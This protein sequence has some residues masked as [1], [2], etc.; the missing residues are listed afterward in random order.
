MCFAGSS[1]GMEVLNDERD[2]NEH[3]FPNKI[4]FKTVSYV[5]PFTGEREAEPELKPNLREL[6][7]SHRFSMSARLPPSVYRNCFQRSQFICEPAH[8]YLSVHLW[9]PE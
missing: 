2:P 8:T 9:D 4:P 1:E 3:Y 7:Y 5:Y 6:K